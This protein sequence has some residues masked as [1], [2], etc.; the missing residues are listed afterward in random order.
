M[1]LVVTLPKWG[2]E[3]VESGQRVH[4]VLSATKNRECIT[5]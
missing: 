4:L 5:I 2:S 1:L 3:I